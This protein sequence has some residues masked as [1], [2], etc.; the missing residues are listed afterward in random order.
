MNNKAFILEVYSI[1]VNSELIIILNLGEVKFVYF[2]QLSSAVHTQ[3]LVETLF[4]KL[5][6]TSSF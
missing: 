6:L 5:F 4:L 3:K 2:D 1:E